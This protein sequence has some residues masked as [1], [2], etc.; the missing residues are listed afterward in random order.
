MF[1][2]IHLTLVDGVRLFFN[3]IL[4]FI[5]CRVWR[6]LRVSTFAMLAR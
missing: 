1:S 3:E 6:L 5:G 2:V 4:L